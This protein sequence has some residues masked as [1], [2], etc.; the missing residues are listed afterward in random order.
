[1]YLDPNSHTKT[2]SQP[3]DVS[4]SFRP[5]GTPKYATCWL[6][7]GPAHCDNSCLYV[8]PKYLDPGY[9]ESDF[10]PLAP[11]LLPDSSKGKIKK[12]L[13]SLLTQEPI[14][15]DPLS[16]ALKDKESYQHIRALPLNPG[17]YVIFTHRIMHWGSKGRKSYKG[18]PRIS[19]SVA[20][21]DPTFEAPYF[22]ESLTGHPSFEMRYS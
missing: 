22:V 21:S 5:D 17:E 12:A 15:S 11:V 1:M 14:V 19:L 9:S 3:D 8:I 13:K 20:F 6:A 2:F 18:E 16:T 10:P 4:A 7:L